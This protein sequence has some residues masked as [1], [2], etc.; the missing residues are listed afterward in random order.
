MTA[1]I[2]MRQ[3]I[4]MNFSAPPS[5]DDMMVMVRHV[6]DTLPDELTTKCENL[7][8]E[9]EEL[10]DEAISQDMD[11][12]N[13]YELLALFH[14]ALE[15]APGVQKKIANGEE[16]KLVVYRRA[17]LDLWCETGE[18]LALLVREI[19]IEELGRGYEFRE[20]DIQDMIRRHHQG[21][22]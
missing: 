12:E 2:Q 22:L 19:V 6:I 20:E 7:L 16:D 5:P 4:V 8:L 10:A 21:L 1:K 15:V 13:P 9:I 17:V 3:E 11:L 18:D 14:S